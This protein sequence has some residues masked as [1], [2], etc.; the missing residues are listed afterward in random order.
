MGLQTQ[1]QQVEEGRP[2]VLGTWLGPA[3]VTLMFNGHMDTSYQGASRGWPGFRASSRTGSSRTAGSTETISN[4]RALA[5]YV[6][7][8]R[9]RRGHPAARRRDDRGGLV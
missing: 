4:R 7:A 1:W 3:G 2:N 9:A 5:C 6:E 8:V